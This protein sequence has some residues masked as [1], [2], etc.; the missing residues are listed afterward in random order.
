MVAREHATALQ[1]VTDLDAGIF[2]M[3][4]RDY[5]AMPATLLDLIRIA[6]DVK[7]EIRANAEE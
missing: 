5:I 1:F 2:T 6:H 7:A 4:L 3:T